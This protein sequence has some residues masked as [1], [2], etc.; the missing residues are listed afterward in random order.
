LPDLKSLNYNTFIFSFTKIPMQNQASNSQAQ[1]EAYQQLHQDIVIFAD[2]YTTTPQILAAGFGFEGIIGVPGLLSESQINLA[3][4]AGAGIVSANLNRNPAVPIRNITSATS[5]VGVTAA[6]FGNVVDPFLDAMPIEFS[7]PLLPSTV[8]P[9]DIQITLNTGEK[10]QPLYAALNPNYDFNERQTLVVFGYFGNRLVPGTN[11]AIY[12]VKVDVIAD[13]T[14]LTVVTAN[15]LQSA[16]GLSQISS[17]PFVSGPQLVGA[18]LSKLSLAGDY[19][20]SGLDGNLP[21]HGYAYYGNSLDQSLYRLRLFTSGGFS[22]DGVSGF[23]PGDFEKYFILRG[24]DS[25]GNAFTITQDQT[26]YITS[27]GVIQVLGIAELGAGLGSGIYYLEDHDNQFDVILS[28]DVAAI[29]KITSVEI[30]DYKTT[31]YSPIF[32]PGGSGDS[33]SWVVTYT[34]PAA[35]QV[36]PILNSLNDPMVVS[37]ASQKLSDYIVDTDLPVAFRLQDPRTGSHLYTDSSTEANR[38][39]SMGWKFESV[40]FAVNPQDAFAKNIY[41]LYNPSQGDYLLTASDQERTSAVAVGYV[42]QGIIFTS[43]IEPSFG[44]EEVYQLFSPTAKDRIYTA[45]EMERSQLQATGYQLE[46]IAFYAPIFNN[47]N[48]APVGSSIGVI[49]RPTSSGNLILG[50]NN[51]NTIVGNSNADIIAAFAGDDLVYGLA[52]NDSIDGG[53]GND[54][55]NG[56]VGNDTLIGNIGND[57]I[58]G[59]DSTSFGANEIDVLIGGAGNDTFILGTPGFNFYAANGNSDFARIAD[60]SFGD[61]IQLNTIPSQVSN[62]STPELGVGIFVSGNLVAIVQ[63]MNATVSEVNSAL[64]IV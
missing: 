64:A 56:G 48:I 44:L 41:R 58:S 27:D 43:Y 2:Y 14:P 28:G 62:I 8:D 63:G 36:F 29:A 24:I 7:H 25:K 32:N 17:N 15:G 46:G 21:N 1:S 12:P 11:G 13:Q 61:S 4:Q 35:A 55:L 37:Y 10:V 31:N 5:L 54:F 59:T 33:P 19:A 26:T 47:E 45:S 38:L 16:V 39:V 49:S 60:F 9:T 57:T 51:P 23:E 42:D 6:G 3:V 20:P 40:P 30:P 22:P 52:G 50:S 34:K 18:K 53:F